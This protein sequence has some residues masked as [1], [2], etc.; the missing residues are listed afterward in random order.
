MMVC[1]FRS[2]IIGIY[3][4]TLAKPVCSKGGSYDTFALPQQSCTGSC[5]P[6]DAIYTTSTK[7]TVY[8]HT[9]AAGSVVS[10]PTNISHFPKVQRWLR[11]EVGA[12]RHAGGSLR[13]GGAG[14]PPLVLIC[15]EPNCWAIQVPSLSEATAYGLGA[16]LSI[17]CKNTQQNI[18]SSETKTPASAVEVSTPTECLVRNNH[19]HHPIFAAGGE[20]PLSFLATRTR[21]HVFLFFP[22]GI[23]VVYAGSLSFPGNT[24]VAFNVIEANVASG[25]GSHSRHFRFFRHGFLAAFFLID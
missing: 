1:V 12:G 20:S 5:P 23:A 7:L 24:M 2:P 13:T 11:T 16:G 15:S 6:P 14:A 25:A 17:I 9:D 19:I 21:L 10:P 8:F 18:S 22:A 3:C 4:N